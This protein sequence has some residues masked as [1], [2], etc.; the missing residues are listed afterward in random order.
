MYYLC[1]DGRL[2]TAEVLLQFANLQR[3]FDETSETL[4]S[5]CAEL[6]RT[7]TGRNVALDVHSHRRTLAASATKTEDDTGAVGEGDDLT[8]V[9]RHAAI[10]GVG[11]VE[12]ERL[13]DSKRLAGALGGVLGSLEGAVGDVCVKIVDELLGALRGDLLV[14]VA[15]EERAT[16]D[17]VV[18][19]K[20]LLNTDELVG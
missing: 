3:N 17:S 9:L 16:V 15:R 11:V 1:D 13:G 20:K 10:D 5:L 4:R 18:L 2:V 7:R 19:L 12:V 8:L 14:V 6:C